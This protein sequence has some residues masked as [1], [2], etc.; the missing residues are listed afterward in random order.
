MRTPMVFA[1]ML[2]AAPTAFMQS[3]TPVFRANANA[4]MLQVTVTAPAGRAAG[5]LSS[6]DFTVLEDGVP[7]DVTLFSRAQE[8]LALSV[9]LDT[10]ASMDEAIGLAQHA[11]IEFIRRL[12][13]AD[14]GQVVA[15]NNH[16]SVLQPFTP[17]FAD[18]EAAIRQ[19]SASGTTALYN[20]LYVA[21]R[22]FD[23]VPSNDGGI[24]RHAIV[25]LS[26]GEDT[27]SQ[28]GFDDVFDL[29]RRSDVSI[30]AI[31]IGDPPLPGTKAPRERS[32]VLQQLAQAT[33][34]RVI[35]I[36]RAKDLLPVYGQIADELAS[37]YTIAYS[38]TAA[39]RDGKWH[40]IAV[41]VGRQNY[42][43]RT[44]TGYLASH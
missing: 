25:L 8:P 28:V 42:A 3:Q 36:D 10:S 44:R 40:A 37:Q 12:R 1:L 27:A 35:F 22:E 24:R 7:Q 17:R 18:L 41:K 4:V 32:A 21:L 31:R 20:A 43:A 14:V 39:H 26:D 38:P 16:V 15:F 9:M 33:G 6:E 5:G 34:G 11:A 23:A 13:P 19:T 30:Y 2:L 29:A